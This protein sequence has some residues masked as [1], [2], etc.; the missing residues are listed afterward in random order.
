MWNTVM[1][2]V[3]TMNTGMNMISSMEENMVKNVTKIGRT[4]ARF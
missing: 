1:A 4:R 3:N 2:G